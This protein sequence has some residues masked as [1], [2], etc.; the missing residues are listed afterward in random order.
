[1]NKV[2]HNTVLMGS[3]IILALTSSLCCIVPLLAMIGGT[4]GAISAISW[5]APLR[6]YLLA[7][8][9]LALGFAFYRAYKPSSKDAC[10]CE[11]KK[12]ILQSKMFLWVIAFASI[13]L[14]TF[15]YY[16]SNFQKS[17]AKHVLE[18]SP[19]VLQ[20]VL[21]IQ[22]MS[23]AACEGHVNKAL[24]KEKGIKEVTTSYVK[25]ESL[26]KYDSSLITLSQ[27]A[28]AVEIETGYKV[29]NIKAN[30]N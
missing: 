14:S 25:G 20:T 18:N 17:S 22:G 13:L 15:P 30:V 23:C 6:P 2:K 7:A 26:V 1:M 10:G 24:Q 3:G 19:T 9:V 16:A 8:T 4:S 21:H 11:E 28:A 29:K 27:I 5:V 12:N